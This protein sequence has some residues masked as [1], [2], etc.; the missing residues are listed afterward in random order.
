MPLF[1]GLMSGTSIDSVDA[2][3]ADV[4]DGGLQVR[5]QYA[6]PIPSDLRQGLEDALHTGGLTAIRA[7]QLDAHVGE[8]FAEAVLGLLN[9]AQVPPKEIVA[10]GSH[11]QTLYHA[12][13]ASPPLTIQV[14]D[15]NVI[16]WRTGVT[17]VADFRRM[18]VAAG[19]QGAPLAPAFHAFAFSSPEMHRVVLNIGGICN[20]SLLPAGGDDPLCGFDTGPGNTLMD[21][22]TRRVLGHPFDQ[23]GAWASSGRVREDLL[24]RLKD[25]EYFGRPPP[26]STGR[27]RFNAAWLQRAVHDIGDLRAEDVQRTLCQLTVVTVTEALRHHAPQTQELFACGGGA[28]NPVLMRLLAESLDECSVATTGDLGVPPKAVE[29]A[30]FA[31]MAHE[32]L[33]GRAAGIPAVTGARGRSTLGGVYM[34]RPTHDD[35]D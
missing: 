29:G 8:L 30:A 26:K 31:W 19:G 13:D 10:I 22:W 15:P 27:E 21:L 9:A 2:V 14:G 3:L 16:A 11:G 5:R 33:R 34:P 18:D 35:S 12:P 23:D 6:H 7:W 1:V 25:D 28:L 17:T 4:H 24:A 20:L 32:R